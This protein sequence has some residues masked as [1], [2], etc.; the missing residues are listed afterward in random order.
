MI[1]LYI[2]NNILNCV[3]FYCLSC[4][5]PSIVHAVAWAPS[6][7]TTPSVEDVLKEREME[8]EQDR[9]QEESLRHAPAKWS[10]MGDGG[11]REF[12]PVRL[13]TSNEGSPARGR[14]TS[15]VSVVRSCHLYRFTPVFILLGYTRSVPDKN[16]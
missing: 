10:P 15:N 8:L 11:R 1:N 3:S 6:G 9:R 7:R 14:N 13:D 5:F 2:N 12:R 16:L 4:M